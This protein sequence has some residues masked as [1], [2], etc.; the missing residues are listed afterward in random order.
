MINST[1]KMFIC[2][3]TIIINLICRKLGLGHVQQKNKLPSPEWYIVL[4]RIGWTGVRLEPYS[5]MHVWLGSVCKLMKV[6][7]LKWRFE[8]PFST[9]IFKY[10]TSHSNL[11]VKQS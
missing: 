3:I 7:I 4:R 2:V 8:I 9:V 11:N 10:M 6:P 5:K 1:K